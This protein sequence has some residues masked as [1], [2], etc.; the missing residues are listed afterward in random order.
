MQP[1]RGISICRTGLHRSRRS[2]L[3]IS[4]DICDLLGIL[5]SRLEWPEARISVG[6]SLRHPLAI[7]DSLPHRAQ[8]IGLEILIRRRGYWTN[9]SNGSVFNCRNPPES[10]PSY[11]PGGTG[12]PVKGLRRTPAWNSRLE[13]PVEIPKH[14]IA[15]GCYAYDSQSD[16][17]SEL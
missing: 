16:I 9:W 6:A 8:S 11:I 2:K 13:I 1:A 10:D 14:C 17:R 4:Y 5:T 12:V 15:I 3:Q 7:G